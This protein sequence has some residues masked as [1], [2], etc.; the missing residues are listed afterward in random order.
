MAGADEEALIEGEPAG[1]LRK[2]GAAVARAPPR[3]L[4][5]GLG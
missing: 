3:A 5:Q 2:L 1:A 4:P